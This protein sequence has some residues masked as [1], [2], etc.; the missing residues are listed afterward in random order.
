MQCGAKGFV[1]DD[2]IEGVWVKMEFG[3]K[4]SLGLG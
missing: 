1:P 3:S 4:W 2:V